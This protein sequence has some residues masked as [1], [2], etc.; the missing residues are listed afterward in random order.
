MMMLPPSFDRILEQLSQQ[1]SGHDLA[2]L[3]D[4]W[5]H[6]DMR[7]FSKLDTAKVVISA[8]L[9]LTRLLMQLCQDIFTVLFCFA[10]LKMLMWI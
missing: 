8:P 1:I 2:G 5:K 6:L 7:I 10:G 4:L 9:P 3:L